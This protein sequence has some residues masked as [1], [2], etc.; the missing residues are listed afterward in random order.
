[1]EKNATVCMMIN[2]RHDEARLYEKEA[3]T[4]REHGRDVVILCTDREGMDSAGIHFVQVKGGSGF[5][6]RVRFWR[7][8]K[9]QDAA[10][11]HIFGRE[12]LPLA[13][14]L[15]R[16][17]RVIWEPEGNV[18]AL[19]SLSA[20]IC[21]SL[22]GIVTAT[23]QAF[24][25]YKP[26][27][28]RTVLLCDYPAEPWE[29]ERRFVRQETE[30]MTVCRIGELSE[31]GGLLPLLQA[32][33]ELSC[34]LC[35]DGRVDPA[36]REQ[37]SDNPAF[38]QENYCEGRTRKE[39]RKLLFEAAVGV[40]TPLETDGEDPAALPPELFSCMAA[41]LPV[42]VSNTPGFAKVVEEHNCGICVDPSSPQE[43]AGAIAYIG[44]N[45]DIAAEM[46]QNG[47]KAIRT[48]YHWDAEKEKLALL[49]RC[50]ISF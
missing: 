33:K 12:L 47:R 28:R 36:F 14:K 16:R 35:L 13:G 50:P 2:G 3:R 49:Y 6:L 48:Q 31:K 10:Y 29:E 34:R 8:A 45:P 9:K 39:L 27:V 15:R 19:K 37:L 41:G 22:Y 42:V 5:W 4:L 11:F 23:P 25:W 46:G 17:G 40:I 26:L 44:R 32:A 24:E 20:R 38:L 1:M 7:A 21:R 43:I 30:Q 18:T